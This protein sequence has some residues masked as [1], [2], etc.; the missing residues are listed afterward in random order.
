M[1]AI[2]YNENHNSS[3][4]TNEFNVVVLQITKSNKNIVKNL[5]IVY[6]SLSK[7]KK[8]KMKKVNKKS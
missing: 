4:K 6:F 3:K 1:C 8:M 7:P 5:C 2:Q